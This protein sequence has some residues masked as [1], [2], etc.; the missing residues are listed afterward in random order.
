MFS[1]CSWLAATWQLW[2]SSFI[3]HVLYLQ[4][5][6]SNMAIVTVIIHTPCS[7]LAV[8]WQQHGNCDSHHSYTMFSTCSWLAATWQ[9]WQSSFIH[10]V[11]YLQLIGSNMAIVTVIIH[12]PC[13][14]LAV[15][16][17]NM[18]IVTV[19][20]Y[21]MAATWQLW[22]SSFIHHVL[23]LQLIGSNMA[24]VTVIIHTPCSLLAVDWQQHGNCDSHHSYTM[25]STCSWL[26]ATWQLWQSSF[27]HH[28]LY[29]Q[30]IGSNMAIVTVIIHTPCSLLAVDWQQHGNCDS[31]HSYTMF[32]TCS[33]LAATWQLWQS[34]FIHHVLYLQLIGSNMAIVTVI[35]H[36]PCSLLAVDWQQHGNCDSH[37]SYTMF[38]T[39]SWLAVCDSGSSN[40]AIV[41]VIIHT[42]CSLLAVD[43]QQHGNCDSH[44]SYTGSKHGNCDSH[45]SYTM[46]STCSWLAAT[47]QL[48]QSSF[49]HHVLYLQL[50]GSNMAIVTVIIHTPCSHHSYTMFSTCILA[51]DWQ[52]HGNCDSHHSYTMFSTCSWL[53]ATWQL[54]QSSF[55]HHVLYL[56]LIGS[57]M[58]I[59]TVII[60]TPCSLLAVDWQQHG[61]CDSHHSYTMFSTCSWLAATWQLWQSSFIHHVLYLQLIGSNMAIVTVIIHTPCSL[62]AVDWQQHGNCDS[63]HSYTM[64]STCSWLAATW[65][66]WQSSFIHHVLYLQ[67]IGSNM[68]IVTVIIHTPCSLLAVDWQQ[69]GNC[70]S[71][72]SYTM[73]STCSWLAA[74]WQ[75]W[76]S[77]FIHHVLYL[78]LIGSNMAIV[79]VIIHTPC[80]LLAVDWQQHGN[81][82]SHHSYTMFSTCSWLAATWQLWQSS[83]IHHVLY[84]QLIGSNMAIVTVIIHTPCS[85]L[86]VDWQQHGNCDSHHSYTMFSTCS[87]LAATWQLWQ[88]S[89]IHHVLYLQLI[90]SN[91]AIVTVIIHTPCSLLAVDWQQ[92]GNCDSHHSYTMFS[93]CSWLA[94]TWQLWQSSFIH[95]VLYLQLIGSN[96][97]IVT[98]IIH[99]P[100]SLLA[101]DWQQHGNCDSHHSYTMFST[102]NCSHHSYTM[103]STRSG[104]NMAIVTV[105]IHTPCS[106]L[107]VDWQQHG[108][109]DS[110]HSYTMFSTCSWLAATWQLWQSSFIHHVLYLQLIGSNMAI[111]TVII[112]TPCSLLAVD[113]QQHGNCDS[114]HSYTMFSTC[115]WL[116]ATWQLWQ[117]SFIHHVLYLQLIGSNMAIVTVIIHTPCSLL[118]V[119]WQQHGNCDSHHSYT[120]FSTCSWLA[121][122]WQL[123]VV[124]VIIH[125]PCSLLAVDWQQHGNCDSHHSYTMFSTC[126]WLA[127]TWQLWQSSFIHHVLYLQLIGS[128]MAIVTV[129]IHTPCSLLAVD[130]QQHGNCDSHHSY[131]MFSTCS[132]LAATWQLWQSSFIHH[133]LYLQLIGSNMAIVTVIIHTPCS[134]LAVDWQQHG[135]CDSHHSYTMFSTCS[136]LAATWQLWQSSFIHHVLY[137]QLIGSNMAIVTV[138]IHTPCSLLAVDWQQHGNCDSHHSYTM[139]STC[140]WLAATWQLW[141]SSFIHHV[142]Y[143]QLIGSNMAIVTVIIHTP[144]SLLAVDWQQHGNCDSHH[145]YTMFSTCSWLAATWQL[146]QSFI[147]HVL[148]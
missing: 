142:L 86:A 63:H 136:W 114:H 15:V 3:H 103:F 148:Y 60:H 30:L 2:Q 119:D 104:S 18:A 1:T 131:T 127:A 75:L 27:I 53:A 57:N 67:L 106:L 122:T 32:S 14:L 46:F 79:T 47:W 123:I 50:I 88:S 59:V 58:A 22:Q 65:Q 41:T 96:M 56:Q 71:H 130:W 17:S 66:L 26:A 31:H 90:G 111:V 95:H 62:L 99:T 54:W 45:H 52:Q 69:H 55:I 48:W 137:L 113:W 147:H 19:D 8:D 97:A 143:L 6:G 128:N 10:H 102:G 94:A 107:A 81:C 126:S 146:W 80:S 61:N 93:T 129:I 117:S 116:A 9:L 74:T 118:A 133:V 135:N 64:F 98:V 20:S 78:Q 100:C 82:D 42:P 105:I 132:W 29:L 23:Y 7:L 112:H 34:S 13:S 43:W 39:C 24:I 120:M 83:F 21:T 108:N 5:I 124:T 16:G 44:H 38:S 121:A 4:L 89:F 85:L 144:C 51:V 77:S 91:M 37:H 40:M 115:S 87:W 145:S 125:T 92:H 84:L 134:L 11:L 140:S 73:F 33:W 36:T 76:Q 109:C 139:F 72:H 110:H 28:V 49:I 101:V 68:A 12:T 35:I 141:Q 25:F 70:D 138:I